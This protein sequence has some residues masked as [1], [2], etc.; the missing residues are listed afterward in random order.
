MKN[1]L[2]I[3]IK[4]R[5]Q[6]QWPIWLIIILPFFFGI[7]LDF[8]KLPAAIKYLLD[9]C[10][11][12]L[13]LYLVIKR[14]RSIS[15]NNK[16]S[17]AGLI[18]IFFIYVSCVYVLNYQSIFYFL[19]G[20]RNNF[21]FYILFFACAVFLKDKD[22][23]DY[24]KFFEIFLW[25]N[26]LVSLIQYFLLGYD[27]DY[28]GGLFGTQVGCNGYTNLFFV[29]M[30][31]RSI[32][33]YLNKMEGLKS[34]FVKCAAMLVV[35]AL[36]EIKFFYLEF[37]MIV[38]AA[39]LLTD[40][41]WR[42]LVIIISSAIIVILGYALL[43]IVFPN[44]VGFLSIEGIL[45]IAASDKGYTSSGDV[46]RLTALTIISKRFLKT[47]L[48]QLFGMGLGNCD[49][50]GYAFLT[51]PF[52]SRYSYLRYQWFSHAFLYLETGCTGLAMFTAFFVLVFLEGIKKGQ[53][54]KQQIVNGQ[55]AAITALCC[56]LIAV[57]NSSLRTE[58]GYM[59][60]FV[61]SMPFIKQNNPNT[62]VVPI[63]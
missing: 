1:R 2:T 58:A 13:T 21:R 49:G 52:Y 15:Q 33:R 50:A 17:L 4:K 9:V 61:L 63:K 26:V 29:I 28:L 43:A 22:I 59:A 14:M 37:I 40:F 34:C 54:T 36:A 35:A 16:N 56:I 24:F 5:S 32:V 8:M 44:S 18:G 7:L 57:Y 11:V 55:I 42:K 53:K 19:W 47:P 3:S 30:S 41:S 6:P 39:V 27:G 31:A 60:Y 45:R 10:W 23:E 38:A 46:N 62:K 51:T 12:L 25:G 20:I 48:Q